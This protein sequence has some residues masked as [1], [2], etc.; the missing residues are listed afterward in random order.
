MINDLESFEVHLHALENMINASNGNSGSEI[1]SFVKGRIL[2]SVESVFG[3]DLGTDFDR[4]GVLLSFMQ[5]RQPKYATRVNDPGHRVSTLTYPRHPFQPDL[6]TLISQ[7]P[8]GLVELTL[9]GNIAIELVSFLVKLCETIKWLSLD[10][11]DKATM[12]RPEMTLQRA[13]YDIQCLSALPLTPFEA[14]LAH[15]LLAF[16]FHLYNELVFHLP[17]ARPLRPV[18]EAFNS[19]TD[20]PRSVW[21][22]RCLLWCSIVIASSWDVQVD[23]SPQKHE[24]LDKLLSSSRDAKTW[25]GTEEILRQFLWHDVLADQLE[26][27]WRAAAF[28]QVRQRRGA[29][30]FE[31]IPHLQI[32]SSS[33][34]NTNP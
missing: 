7:L 19:R 24:L 10:D 18:V 16:C 15:G 29:S 31:S 2:A 26:I 28:R 11:M 12:N 20:I 17:L 14:R 21:Q 33:A 13:I 27:C 5:A 4:F 9:A 6:C 30:Q 3:C 8:D 25:T 1:K 23:A 32:E 22:Q 34:S